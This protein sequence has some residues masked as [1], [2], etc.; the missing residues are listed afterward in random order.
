MTRNE[1]IE[2]IDGGN[3]ILF[4]CNGKHY[5][6]VMTES[7]PDIAEQSTC[8]N[9]RAYKDGKELMD[10]YLIDGEALGTIVSQ[11]VVTFCS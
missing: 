9:R 8:A 7:G 5:A 2:L 3:D 11:C 4:D 1:F 10:Q 6:I